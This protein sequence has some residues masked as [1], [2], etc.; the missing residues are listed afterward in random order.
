[1]KTFHT[2]E[3]N[4][5]RRTPMM[6]DST[7]GK[8]IKRLVTFFTDT[9][10]E[11]NRKPALALVDDMT[12]VESFLHH[13]QTERC[14]QKSTAARYIHSLLISAKYIHLDESHKDYKDVE[15]VHQICA[16]RGQL[17]K[18]QVLEKS[19]PSVKLLWLQFQE[20]VR[21]LF[22]KYEEASGAIKARLHMDFCFLSP[23]AVAKNSEPCSL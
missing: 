4:Y 18:A 6:T 14:V 1:M 19:M 20:L 11:F 21:N 15:T 2:S 10:K 17:E 13:L 8:H 7:W 9:S 12:L 5:K 22:R 16:L 23:Q 3:L